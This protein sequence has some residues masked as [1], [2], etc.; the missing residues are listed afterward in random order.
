MPTDE[1][2]RAYAESL[3]PIYREILTAFPRIEPNRKQGYG[4][5]F[6]T[7]AADFED[8]ELGFSLGEII[9][10]CEELEQNNLAEIKHRIFVHPTPLGERLVA[11]VAGRQA[12]AVTVPKLPA[13]PS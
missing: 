2:L 3:P 11:V 12:P 10:A 7:L 9:Q 5:A 8:R 13:L 4:L 6:Q 1:Q